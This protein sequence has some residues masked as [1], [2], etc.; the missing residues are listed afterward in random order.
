MKKSIFAKLFV[1]F[2]LFNAAGFLVGAS[3]E[4]S[5]DAT[6]LRTGHFDYRMTKAGK[7]IAKF[8]VNV[9]KMADGNFRFTGEATGFNQKWESIATPMFQTDLGDAANATQG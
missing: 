3:P 5:F 1:G 8:T 6:R 2:G 4:H 7:E 9:E